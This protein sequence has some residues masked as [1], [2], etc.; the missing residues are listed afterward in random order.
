MLISRG[1]N[2]VFLCSAAV[3]GQEMERT[4]FRIDERKMYA[5]RRRCIKV[6]PFRDRPRSQQS[7]ARV[8]K[9][10]SRLSTSARLVLSC[11]GARRRR[12]RLGTRWCTFV[13]MRLRYDRSRFVLIA[14]SIM[15][16]LIRV[17]RL[18]RTLL[19]LLGLQF[20]SPNFCTFFDIEIQREKSSF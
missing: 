14:A 17:F 19:I 2:P 7:T 10:L 4:R 5:N 9:L 15:R 16:W 13:R 11:N 8:I 12:R 6:R 18:L 3:V 20:I 1:Q